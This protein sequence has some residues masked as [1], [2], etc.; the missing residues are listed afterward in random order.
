MSLFEVYI[1]D[2]N[3]L[4]P[5]YRLSYWSFYDLKGT[6]VSRFYHRLHIDMMEIL[7]QMTEEQMF[8]EYARKWK[9]DYV[10]LSF[11]FL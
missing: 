4:L 10:I 11:S 2:L 8:L 9:K 6:V 1:D 3:I 7:Y 5:R